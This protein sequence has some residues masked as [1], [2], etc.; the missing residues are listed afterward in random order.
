M[1]KNALIPHPILSIVLLIT[2]LLLNNTV[3]AGHIVLGA[4]LA[5][6]IPWFTAAFWQERVCAKNPMVFFKFAF[7]VLYD[8]VV[9]SITVSKQVLSPNENLKP[10]FF[11]LPLDIKHPLGIS[12]LA[13]TISLTP[14]TV[15]C[16]LSEDKTFLII[17]ALHID[18]K[19]DVINE[20]KQRYEKPLMEVFTQC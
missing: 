6:L 15:S 19:D 13:S 16:D 11:E 2:W 5:I 7:V 10:E 14:G 18:N 1:K 12:T 8:I 9:A 17:H 4:I 3:A 20:I